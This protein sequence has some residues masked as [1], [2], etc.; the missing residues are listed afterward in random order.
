MG[1]KDKSLHASNFP[2]ISHMPAEAEPAA[3]ECEGRV[4]AFLAAKASSLSGDALTKPLCL[5]GGG[6]VV[7]SGP[8][9][10]NQD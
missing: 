10:Y 4:P 9:M 3:S 2:G 1:G 7:R 5:Q 8:S 6:D